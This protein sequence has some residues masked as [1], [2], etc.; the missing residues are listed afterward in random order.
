M[1]IFI[2]NIILNP[3][4]YYQKY[5]AREFEPCQRLVLVVDFIILIIFIIIII[6]VVVN[7]E[8]I[9]VVVESC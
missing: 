6:A 1:K 7:V 9:S 3:Q 8:V 2:I 4:N 5:A